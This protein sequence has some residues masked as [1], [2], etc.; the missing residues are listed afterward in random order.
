MITR[1]KT[2]EALWKELAPAVLHTDDVTTSSQCH[3]LRDIRT[4]PCPHWHYFREHQKWQFNT[5]MEF[6]LQ[7]AYHM[8]HYRPN[9]MSL[10]S[11]EDSTVFQEAK[12][13]SEI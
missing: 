8:K 13:K 1:K 5:L 3:I 10:L 6:S 2:E 7:A 12:L 11:T 4:I 9:F